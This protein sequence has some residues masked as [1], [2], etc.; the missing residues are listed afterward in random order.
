MPIAEKLEIIRPDGAVAFHTLDRSKGVTNIGRH[1]ENDVVIDSPRVA[2]FHAVLDHRERPYHV[3]ILSQEGIT[4]LNGQNVTPN[5]ST[6]VP[7]WSTLEID[8]HLLVLMEGEVAGGIQPAIVPSAA[9]A[10]G[11]APPPL[12]VAE[13]PAEPWAVPAPSAAPPPFAAVL[14]PRL[15][16]RPPD[17]SDESIIVELAEREWTVD[18]EQPATLVVTLVNGS[19]IVARFNVRL[20]GV[21]ESWVVVNPPQVNLNEGERAAVTISITPPRHPS[22]RAGVHHVAVVVT[23]PNLPGHVSQVGGTLFVNPFY[24]F[25][26]GEL[27]PKQ[28]TLGG[29]RPSGEAVFQIA[30]RGNSETA[31]HLE[32]MDDRR[33]CNFEF[34]LPGEATALARQA[35]LRLTPEE[36]F[37]I[38]VHIT[39]L[40]RP[41]IGLRSQA[42][43]FTVT[44]RPL[45]GDVTPRS[46]LGQV[47][48]R[49]LIG[50]LLLALL[51]IC[52][53]ALVVL[54]FR[55]KASDFAAAPPQLSAG[56][57]VNLSWLASLFTNRLSIRAE[58]DD[59]QTAFFYPERGA[60]VHQVYP[61]QDTNYTLIGE[62]LLSDIIDRLRVELPLT[63]TVDVE[64]LRP[65]II[66]FTVDPASISTGEDV[67]LMWETE[68]ADQISMLV[69][70]SV[71][72]ERI[73][74]LD[75]N[76]AMRLTPSVTTMY[77]L[78]AENSLGEEPDQA[79][80]TV[81]VTE[82]PL[83]TPI[84]QRFT[85]F[86]LSIT[87][88]QTVTLDW[89][90]EGATDVAIQNVG[91]N[92]PSQYSMIHAPPGLG[93]FEYRLSAFYRDGDRSSEPA[94]S[95]I[96]P[97]MIL[98]P[99]PE[100][101]APVIDYFR[102]VPDE[103]VAGTTV[104]LTWSV[105]GD[106]TNIEISGPTLGAV[107]NL[108]AQ[109]SIQVE[110]SETTFFMLTAYNGDVSVSEMVQLT[111]LEPTPT[112]T[113]PP[114]PPVIE[115]FEAEGEQNRDDV[116]EFNRQVDIIYYRT[117]TPRAIVRLTWTTSNASTVHLFRGTTDLGEFSVSGYYVDWDNPVISQTVRY[118]LNAQNAVGDEVD[119]Y[120]Q[121]DALSLLTP[122]P[123]F[124]V[125][126]HTT[127]TDTLTITWDYD[128]EHWG[129]SADEVYPIEGFVIWRAPPPYTAFEVAADEL[130]LSD[131]DCPCE[132]EED[133]GVVCGYAY[134]VTAVYRDRYGDRQE[135]A[136]SPERFYS[137]PCPTPTP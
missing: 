83:P 117:T 113:P 99:T 57:P 137:G 23:S 46:L 77:T 65:R 53:L 80:R 118:R 101:Q 6:E 2:P 61:T 94:W 115:S 22:S 3:M 90:V 66:E 9:A 40:S 58:T 130:E 62:N 14:V 105:S 20:E 120:V 38:P 36:T 71:A 98:Q 134:Y 56:D 72:N 10:A 15:V 132:W 17:L 112:P 16:A 104:E 41:L 59:G 103:A 39:P 135:T 45:E 54:I 129:Y 33:A 107:S 106:T 24:E 68:N 75:P 11:I 74:E 19:P 42:H 88:G 12:A 27:S 86:P 97:V 126:G 32:A 29:R 18:V 76:G 35:D 8:G 44:A 93:I 121:I 127:S 21:D 91:E 52:L 133:T 108:P 60:T 69:E 7:S 102:A 125:D 30:N 13:M 5:V 110:A 131:T 4:Q 128:P 79:L 87:Q 64:P 31:F 122:P 25:A 67:T 124:D 95:E 136:A 48:V 85:V 49:P 43:S 114:P 82:P 81:E 123:P 70:S 37:A 89:N 84:I 111:V 73:V 47:K 78:V 92:Y 50:P 119:A 109:D 100:P 1:P 116:E 51:A 28:Q 96:V 55:P 34:E 26:V 63:Y